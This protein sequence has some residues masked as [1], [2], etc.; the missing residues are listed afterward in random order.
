M[1]IVDNARMRGLIAVTVAILAGAATGNEPVAAR[2]FRGGTALVLGDVVAT[3]LD[4][5]LARDLKRDDFLI[6]E[7]GRPQEI[8]QFQVVDLEGIAA[9]SAD[10]PG[11]FSNRAEPGAVFA[12]VLDDMNVDA[13]HTSLMS[14]SP[15]TRRARQLGHDRSK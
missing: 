14:T 15:P 5:N 11:V 12:I 1:E 7:D 9:G 6:F 10:P 4:G 13:R 3:R 2:Q 8:K